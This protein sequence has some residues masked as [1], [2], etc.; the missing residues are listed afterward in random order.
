MTADSVWEE[1]ELEE[2]QSEPPKSNIA[3]GPFM[4]VHK[5]LRHHMT[6]VSMPEG[7]GK[8]KIAFHRLF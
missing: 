1:Q 7:S 6:T 2:T 8:H 3:K 4:N 5:H